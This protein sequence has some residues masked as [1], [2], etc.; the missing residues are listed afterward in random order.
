MI[1]LCAVIMASIAIALFMRRKKT[2]IIV[3]IFGVV[4]SYCDRTLKCDLLNE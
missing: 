2:G 1:L 3:Q 4:Y